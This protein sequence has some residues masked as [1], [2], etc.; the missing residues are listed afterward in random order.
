MSLIDLPGPGSYDVIATSFKAPNY[1]VNTFF[2]KSK[3]S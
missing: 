1:K 2:G 3:R